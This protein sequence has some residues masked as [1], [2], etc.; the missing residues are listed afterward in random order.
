[1]DL[2]SFDNLLIGIQTAISLKGLCM[3]SLG[4]ILGIL[5]GAAPGMSPSMGV[6]LL[7]PFSYGMNPALAFIFFVAVYQAANYGGSITAIAINAPGT[8]ASV[9]TAI[10]GYELTKQGKPGKA[11]GAAVLSSAIGGTI[12]ALLLI[13]LSGTIAE[14]GIQFGPAEYFW[15]A[16]FGLSTVIAFGK[17]NYLTST[18]GILIGVLFTTIGLDPF[19]GEE[20][21]T[22]GIIEL[23]DGISFIPAMIGLFALAEIFTQIEN[24]DHQKNK[25]LKDFSGELPKFSEFKET[26]ATLIKS[27]FIGTFIGVIPGAGSTIAS[28]ISYGEAKRAS[29]NPDELGKGSLEGVVACEAANSSSVGGALVPLL[30]LGIPGSATD[31]VLLGALSLHG[32][33]AGPALFSTNPDIVY[34]IFVSVLAANVFIL[35]FGLLG[36]KIW[37]RVISTPKPLLFTFVIAMCILGSYTIKNSIFEAWVCLFFGVAGWILKKLSIPP[38]PIVLGLVLGA[39]IEINLRRSMLAGGVEILY[40]SNLAIILA[41]LS[42]ISFLFPFTRRFI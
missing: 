32:L 34:G 3:I 20:R 23:F 28:F 19:T 37:L 33:V 10:D 11:L 12:G 8:P 22:F 36:N 9:V 40:S 13:F 21:L 27:S 29:K 5:V 16:V 38:A 30:A 41:V 7:V 24:K 26:I 18:I 17:A 1:M 25:L 31:A 39:M 6:A 42:L 2:I 4:V 14:F 15:L 35:A